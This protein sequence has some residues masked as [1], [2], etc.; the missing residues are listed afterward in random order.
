MWSLNIFLENGKKKKKCLN[1]SLEKNDELIY[2]VVSA[3]KNYHA[4]PYRL[5][6]HL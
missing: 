2:G 4:T 5:G 6:N 1:D 3:N